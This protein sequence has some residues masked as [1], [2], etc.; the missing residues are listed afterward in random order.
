MNPSMMKG[1]MVGGIA[2]VVL[3]ASGVTYQQITKPKFAQVVT[4]KEVFETV[5]TPREHCED[6]Q[7]KKQAP[8]KDEHHHGDATNHHALHHR[9]IHFLLLARRRNSAPVPRA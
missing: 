7:V 9:R 5:V 6:V 1:V 8:V 3:G 2:M 4:S